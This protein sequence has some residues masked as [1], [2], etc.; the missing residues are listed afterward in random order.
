M[1]GHERQHRLKVGSCIV[2][3]VVGGG[4]AGGGDGDVVA[5]D[6]VFEALPG[7]SAA[8]ASEL[9]MLAAIFVDSFSYQYYTNNST[10]SSSS[11]APRFL[12]TASVPLAPMRE[13]RVRATLVM[14]IPHAYAAPDTA[15]ATATAA[16]TT[17]TPAASTT[18]STTLQDVRGMSDA[19]LATLRNKVQHHHVHNNQTCVVLFRTIDSPRTC[20]GFS[21]RSWHASPSATLTRACC[22]P[23]WRQRESS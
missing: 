9:E 23:W 13:A 12:A 20:S 14:D 19:D 6:I 2:H 22:G 18:V 17:T 10:S 1:A 7:H 16:A 4:A 15:T 21:T 3:T 5:A 8:L 11:K